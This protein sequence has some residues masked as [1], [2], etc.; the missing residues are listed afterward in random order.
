MVP[1]RASSC[2]V[3]VRVLSAA[4]AHRSPCTT[5]SWTARPTTTARPAKKTNWSTPIRVVV[6][7][8]LR[9]AVGPGGEPQ[10]E[11]LGVGRLAEIQLGPGLRHQDRTA[12]RLAN[13]RLELGPPGLE[14]Q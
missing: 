6:V 13:A 10:E 14:G 3:L 2:R 9:T 11:G 5:C 4:A 1:R 12:G 7:A 8:I